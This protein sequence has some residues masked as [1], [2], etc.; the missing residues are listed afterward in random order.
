MSV[1][2]VKVERLCVVYICDSIYSSGVTS[3]WQQQLR[4]CPTKQRTMLLKSLE[5]H[6]PATQAFI[7]NIQQ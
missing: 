2:H 3:A 6:M 7:K 1:A 4:Q 5:K